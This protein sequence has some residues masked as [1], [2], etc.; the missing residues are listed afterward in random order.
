MSV[1]TGQILAKKK[2]PYSVDVTSTPLVTEDAIIFGTARNGM[3]ALDRENLERRWNYMTGDAL[4]YT[5]PYVCTPASQIESSPVKSGKLVLFGASDGAFYALDC[6]DGNLCWKH[7]V[8]AP[9]MSTVAV[10]GNMMFGADY[11]GN[12]YGFVS[13]E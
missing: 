3:V 12:V 5:S 1:H 10:S 8:G 4:I 13:K 7:S 11:A 6:A 9:V 2:L